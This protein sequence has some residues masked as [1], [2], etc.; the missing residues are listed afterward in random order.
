[1]SRTKIRVLH[2][3]TRLDR[4]GSAENTLLTVAA[5]N[6]KRYQLALV[7][8]PSTGER[9]PTQAR[10]EERGVALTVLPHLVRELR[11][12]A[13]LRALWALWRLFKKGDH[14]IVHTHTSKA[15][16]VGRLAARLAGVPVIIHT[17]HG[18][19]FYGY[20][21]PLLTRVFIWLERWAA[22]FSDRII[23]LTARGAQDHIDFGIAASEKF[24]VIHSGVDFSLAD[25]EGPR[26][27][28][29]RCGLGIPSD[30]LVIGTLGRLT[31]IKAQNILVEAFAQV[32]AKVDDAWLL[33]VGDGEEREALLTLARRLDVEDRLVFAGWHREI[34]PMLEAMDIFALPSLNEGMGKALVEAMYAGLPCVATRVGGIP[35]LIGDEEVGLLVE[36]SS[37]QELAAALCRLASDGEWR[38][39]MGQAARCRASKYGVDQMVAEIEALYEEVLAEKGLDR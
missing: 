29:V 5:T 8:G 27:E 16:L 15:G 18:H 22:G 37:P 10:A 14:D 24:V 33:L 32:N 36:P 23:T 17:P 21:G 2:A 26:R 3:I 12:L 11:P 1:M 31:A 9:S 25:A 28:A 7:T 13:D 30:G 20:F 34:Y 4:G 35:E 19:V 6:S 38:S 39:R